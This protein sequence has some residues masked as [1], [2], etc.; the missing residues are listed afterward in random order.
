[1]SSQD[2]ISLR[3]FGRQVGVSGEYVRRA[4]ADGKIPASCVGTTTLTSGRTRPVITDP[5]AAAQ[6]WGRSRDVTQVRDKSVMAA[7]ARRG[8]QQR[9]GAEPAATAA[10]PA[11]EKK[12]RGPPVQPKSGINPD[13]ADALGGDHDDE[14]DDAD[15]LRS[16]AASKRLTEF[17]KSE[18]ARLDHEERRGSLVN[19]EQIKAAYVGMITTAKTKLLA[20]PTKAKSR[21][22]TLTITDIEILEDLIA[23]ALAEVADGR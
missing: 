7:G 17:Y 11:V 6:H 1:M 12:R 9:R 22:H 21:I 15:G 14:P 19:A 3:E 4:V 16:I 5:V 18:D 10:P 8:W 2:G 13:L 20:V 23:E